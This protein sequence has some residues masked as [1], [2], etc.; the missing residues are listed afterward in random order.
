MLR[1]R[2]ETLT[3]LLEG[4]AARVPEKE[5]IAGPRRRLTYAQFAAAARRVAEG[6]AR[7]GVGPGDR[8]AIWVPNR[9]EYLVLQFALA[10]LGACAVHVNTRFRPAEV[11]HLLGRARPSALATAWGFQGV[12]FPALLAEV[13]ADARA[14]LRFVI[15]LDAHGASRVAGLPVLPW[16]TLDAAPERTQDDA[17][18]D[19]ACLTFTTSGT[20]SGPKLVLHRQSAIA[21]HGYDV[22]RRIGTDA[23]GA[24][25]LIA[26][27]LCGTYGNAAAMGGIAGGAK[28]VLMDRW[29]AQAADA[30]IRAEGVTHW[31]ALDEMIEEVLEAAAGRPYAPF[32]VT[33]IAGLR[34]GAARLHALAAELN[35]APLNLYGSSEMQGLYAYQDPADPVR[36]TIG[37]GRPVNADAQVRARDPE[38]GELAERGELEFRAPSM[39]IGYLNDEA[40]TAR[41]ITPDGF[42]RSGD[43]GA[44]HPDGFGFD[45]ETR[46]GDALRLSGFLVNP[47][48]IESFLKRQ[49]GVREAQVVGVEGG[50]VAIAFVQPEPGATLEEA[51]LLEACRRDLA[52]YKVP[53]RIL[54]IAEFPV[55]QSANGVKI[56]RVKL[57]EMAEQALRQGS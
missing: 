45:F 53:R 46:M 43:L 26:V 19:S 30:L 40:A 38:T 54:P 13:A 9:P 18:P 5:A 49:P 16:E 4:T 1:L 12:D 36:R 25:V 10:R 3:A 48:E 51:T 39:F 17:T 28:L 47:E 20:T 14:P 55:T 23:E 22:M 50:T 32:R 21:G 2:P 27:P 8:V 11:A 15:G 56:Q 34:P 57:R 35:L 37:G 7:E 31:H 44:V 29:D 42:F 41:A 6:L 33:G 24:A 52:R